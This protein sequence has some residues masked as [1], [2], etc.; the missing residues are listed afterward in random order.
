G[1]HV[2]ARGVVPEEE[3]LARLFG[4][5]H[6]IDRIFDQHVVEGGHVVL[7]VA[8]AFALSAIGRAPRVRSGSERSFVDN[9]LLANFAPARLLRGIVGVARPAMDEVARA[10][11]ITD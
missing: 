6:E 5:L 1:P 10:Y 2:H 7:G 11:R 8:H 4:P 9:L 3:R